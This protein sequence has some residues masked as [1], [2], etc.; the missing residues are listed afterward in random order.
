MNDRH[1]GLILTNDDGSPSRDETRRK[2][3][4]D[5]TP[6]KMVEGKRGVCICI[7]NQSAK[8][9]E[10][11]ARKRNKQGREQITVC[12]PKR[13]TRTETGHRHAMTEKASR[14]R[15]FLD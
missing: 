7:P 9:S 5:T 14:E 11:I 12:E 13:P 10:R 8:R 2:F 1:Q 4:Q 6:K 3:A 15:P